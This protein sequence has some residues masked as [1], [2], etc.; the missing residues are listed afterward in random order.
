MHPDLEKM[1]PLQKFDLETARLRAELA[2]LP[3][4]LAALAA[5]VDGLTKSVATNAEA[6]KHEETLR[7]SQE[8]DVKSRHE[9]IARL[10]RQMDVVT[11]D[12]QA[13]ALE[14]EITFSEKEISRL[15]DAEI[16]SM[17]RTEAL[18]GLKVKFAEELAEATATLARE[19]ERGA[20]TLAAHNA[21]LKRLEVERAAV[22]PTISERAL[23]TY[24]RV[25]KAKG[26]GLAEA[27]DHKCMACQMMVR[28]QKWIEI[29]DRSNDELL[30]TCETCGR[31]LYFDATHD[32]P[33]SL[34][35]QKKSVQAT[36]G[37]EEG[38]ARAAE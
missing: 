20:A 29:S 2:A 34:A 11:N 15:E 18:E 23:A 30:M 5:K 36:G 25:S 32:R 4:M 19:R 17:E 33:D 21:E 28:P 14:H 1:I 10:K 26:T 22:R 13:H 12:Q 9:K 27:W 3:K 7:R 24:D 16:E 31:W 6:L 8:V 35:A 37:S 38:R